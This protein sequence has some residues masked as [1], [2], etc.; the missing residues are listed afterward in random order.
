MQCCIKLFA[1][2]S[3]I[4]RFQY[5]PSQV[6]EMMMAAKQLPAKPQHGNSTE[7]TEPLAEV[8]TR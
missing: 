2:F 8:R 4:L 7:I 3:F 6:R 5:F 1:M